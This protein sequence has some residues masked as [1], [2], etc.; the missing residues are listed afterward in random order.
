MCPVCCWEDDGQDEHEAAEVRG[1]PN[2]MLSF[3]QAQKNFEEYGA[4]EESFVGSVRK[5][6]HEEI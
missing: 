1:G 3:T 2:G 6:Q 4:I 5:P